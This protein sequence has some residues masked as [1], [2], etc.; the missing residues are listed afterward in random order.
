M[1]YR[2]QQQF[3]LIWY[4]GMQQAGKS[5]NGLL[6]TLKHVNRGAKDVTQP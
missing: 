3:E 5:Q 2:R 6:L 1:R 4:I